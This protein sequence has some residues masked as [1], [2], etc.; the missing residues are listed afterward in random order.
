MRLDLAYVIGLIIFIFFCYLATYRTIERFTMKSQ[1]DFINSEYKYYKKR[2]EDMEKQRSMAIKFPEMD[3]FYRYERQRPL[4]EQLVLDVMAEGAAGAG[5]SEVKRLSSQCAAIKDCAGLKNSN[6]NKGCGYCTASDTFLM[7]NAK[8]PLTDTCSGGWSWTPEVCK[9]NREKGL[10]SKLKSCLGMVVDG[11]TSVCGWCKTSNKAFV[12][13][14]GKGNTLS[15]KYPD[16]KCNKIIAPGK[17]TGEDIGGACAD[18]KFNTGPHSSE[19]LR[20]LWK[21][22]GCSAT[23]DIAA[24]MGDLNNSRVKQ[25]NS[26]SGMNV[27]QDMKKLRDQ[28]DKCDQTSYALCYGKG[29]GTKAFEPG[30]KCHKPNP[31]HAKAAAATA[32]ANAAKTNALI[33]ANEAHQVKKAAQI[34]LGKKMRALT[35]Q[36]DDLWRQGDGTGLYVDQRI[37]DCKK[38]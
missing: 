26:Q 35:C 11:P 32:V 7:G 12:V 1:K 15:P 6:I 21:D 17:C 14:K 28:A 24:K 18:G 2:K 8:G 4:G 20:K 16:D 25:W 22:V 9:K 30:G 36:G 10:C 5:S 34:Q 13:Q 37:R 33:K 31:I 23:S 38:G 27:Y 19:C 29:E 3:N